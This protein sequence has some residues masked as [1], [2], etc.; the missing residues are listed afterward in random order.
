VSGDFN[1][2][3]RDDI[4]IWRPSEARFH[5]NI[6]GAL[7][8]YPFG[9]AGD[10]PVIGDWDG[11]GSDN[12]AVFRPSEGRWHYQYDDGSIHYASWGQPV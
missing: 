6:N 2:D 8:L 11:T 12:L 10:V 5:L 1:K 4:G 7:A 9:A 3:G